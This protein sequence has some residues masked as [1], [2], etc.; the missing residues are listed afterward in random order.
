MNKLIRRILIAAM[1]FCMIFAAS[2]CNDNYYPEGGNSDF[3]L[4]IKADKNAYNTE[5]E[6]LISVTFENQSD[7]DLEIAY[8]LLFYPESTTGQFPAC[9]QAPTTTKLTFKKGDTIS[10]TERLG[11]YFPVGK[12]ELKYSAVFYLTWEMTEFGWEK[13]DDRVE[14]W[15]NSIKFTITES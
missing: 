11:G 8:Y 14:I 2:G 4:T 3:V 6:I 5:D 12:H 7:T 15:S 10:R 9:E 1:L 13:T